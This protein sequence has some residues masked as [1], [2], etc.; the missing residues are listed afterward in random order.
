MPQFA[1]KPHNGGAKD[2]E[3]EMSLGSSGSMERVE[4]VARRRFACPQS[5][6][7]ARAVAG[8]LVRQRTSHRHHLA[9]SRRGERRLSRL[10]LLHCGGGTQDQI[11]R[12]AL[13]DA[14]FADLASARAPAAGDRRLP[15]QAVW[16]K[17]R[18]GGRPSQPHAGRASTARSVSVWPNAPPTSAAGK[19][20][21]ARSTAK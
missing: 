12:H 4:P 17:S 13:G 15:H 16:A 14:D 19:P 11:D 9:S 6:A 20:P 10:L 2:G 18:R 7:T 21:L 3:F 5:V 1:N 8:H